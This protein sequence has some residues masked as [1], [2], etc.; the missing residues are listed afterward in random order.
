[1]CH[2]GPS[3]NGNTIGGKPQLQQQALLQSGV[4][5]RKRR[6]SK[7]SWDSGPL[8]REGF[9]FHGGQR[10]LG[11]YIQ[12]SHNEG[13]SKRS[14]NRGP[15]GTPASASTDPK[16]VVTFSQA[17]YCMP[18]SPRIKVK[19]KNSAFKAA[20]SIWWDVS[21][22]LLC[23][24]FLPLLGVHVFWWV[25]AFFLEI[26]TIHFWIFVVDSLFQTNSNTSLH[27]T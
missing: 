26:S 15:Q 8:G 7:S 1:M 19:R 13:R 25:P 12:P 6:Q 11:V 3:N 2:P 22:P 14:Y 10:R 9:I 4:E 5:M 16:P 24:I 23:S 27:I 17:M 18:G 20:Y 21:P